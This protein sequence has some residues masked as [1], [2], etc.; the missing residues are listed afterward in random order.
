[1]LSTL[2][3]RSTNYQQLE[4]LLIEINAFEVD[5][6]NW[7]KTGIV[8]TKLK[9]GWAISIVKGIS[10][11]LSRILRYTFDDT[12]FTNSLR[13]SATY[14]NRIYY[15][16]LES[17]RV[18]AKSA[19]FLYQKVIELLPGGTNLQLELFGSGDYSS[20]SD[21]PILSTVKK[22]LDKVGVPTKPARK[23]RRCRKQKQSVDPSIG[24]QL[25]LNLGV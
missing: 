5:L 6:A 13:E 3:I 16:S 9:A 15:Q 24:V 19:L 21:K 17:S 7:I 12:A 25:E 10:R 1:M 23:P 2:S 11:N 4:S 20:S 8:A 14:L 18:I 22:F